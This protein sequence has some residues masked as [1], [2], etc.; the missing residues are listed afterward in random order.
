MLIDC[1]TREGASGSPVF[2]Y[3]SSGWVNAESMET[4]ERKSVLISGKPVWRF[5][6]VYSGRLRGDS[7]VGMVWKAQA[8]RELVGSIMTPPRA[9]QPRRCSGR[10]PRSLRFLGGRSLTPRSLGRLN[11]P[12]EA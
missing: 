10:P 6:G 5:L 1:R 9:A 2:A 12:R 11:E 4:G 7:D 8:V 3:R